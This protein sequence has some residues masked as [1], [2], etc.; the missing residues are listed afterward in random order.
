MRNFW[1]MFLLLTLALPVPLAWGGNELDSDYATQRWAGLFSDQA[2]QTDLKQAGPVLY[3]TSLTPTSFTPPLATTSRLRDLAPETEQRRTQGLLSSTTWLNGV[4]VTETEVARNL[5]GAD[6]LQHRVP[7][8]THSDPAQRMFRL[9]LTGTA[10]PVRYGMR[11]RSS[12]QAFLNG[13]DQALREVWGEWNTGWVTLRSAIG[14]QWNNVAEDPTRSRLEQTY[15]RVGLAWTRPTW[16]DITLTYVHNSLNSTRDPLGIAPLRSYN[17]TLE[18]AFAYTGADW[19][20]RFAS[21]YIF[22]SDLL[23][24]GAES[25]T[26]MQMFTAN[27]RP[28]STMTISS[29]LAYREEAQSWSGIRIHSPSALV[30]LQYR[31][32]QQV[33]I[34]AVGNYVGT[35]SSDRL[36][37]TELVGGKGVLAW[38]LQQSQRWTTLISLEAGYNRTTNHVASSAN[39]EDISGLL[40]IVLAAL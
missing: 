36:M 32:S 40:R 29:A 35:R 22:G 13:P 9:G 3:Q 24:G 2:S 10:G 34:S 18:S 25:I 12:G 14:E 27:F 20:A 30:S 7:G 5:G 11:S 33:L 38:D 26:R 4:F 17:H 37:H 15:R 31:Q 19:T 23:R 21:S 8:D 39:R 16:P 6:W 28:L 1:N